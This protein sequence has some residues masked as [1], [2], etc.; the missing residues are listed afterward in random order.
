MSSEDLNKVMLTP[1]DIPSEALTGS[2]VTVCTFTRNETADPAPSLTMC[3]DG[4]VD[5]RELDQKEYLVLND[6]SLLQ[7]TL[8][9]PADTGP[10]C[11]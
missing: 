4:L 2:N 9:T 3:P 1:K 7:I 8:R 5:L 6:G 11:P 10:I